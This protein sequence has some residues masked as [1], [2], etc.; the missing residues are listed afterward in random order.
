M[1][2]LSGETSDIQIAI[3]SGPDNFIYS[4]SFGNGVTKR[5]SDGSIADANFIRGNQLKSPTDIV[6]NSKGLV[7]IADYDEEDGTTCFNNGKIRVFNTSGVQIKIISTEYFRPIGLAIDKN[8]NLYSA[9]YSLPGTCEPNDSRIRKFDA[10][11]YAEIDKNE[12][13]VDKPFRIAV[14]SK[15]KVFVSQAVDDKNGEV[16]IFDKDLNYVNTLPNTA[17]KSPGSLIVDKYDYLHVIDYNG[18]IDFSK[19]INYEEL[20]SDVFAASKLIGE[21]KKGQDGKSIQ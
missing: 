16:R 21:I 1:I 7:F 20:S 2:P 12:T 9:E 8:D 14:D 19:F 3:T 13:Q 11:T 4:L 5:N 17:L 18:G 6:V 15:M 10:V